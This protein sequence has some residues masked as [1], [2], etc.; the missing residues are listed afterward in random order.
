MPI[1]RGDRQLREQARGAVPKVER[2]SS[3][4]PSG[5]D[6]MVRG[7]GTVGGGRR[8]GA[9]PP[10]SR[11]A[12]ETS[13]MA[14]VVLDWRASDVGCSHEAGVVLCYPVV[15]TL[16]PDLHHAVAE[17]VRRL[18]RD[19]PTATRPEWTTRL[20][21]GRRRYECHAVRVNGLNATYTVM[22]FERITLDRPS[23]ATICARFHLTERESEAVTLLAYGLTNKQ[24]AAR[25][26]V[27]ANTVKAFLHLVM[28]KMGV[29]TR[30][31]ILGCVLGQ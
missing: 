15:P 22:R 30:A 3:V 4:V 28:S 1:S 26:A 16:E 7:Q 5:S 10:T 18:V 17:R 13:G 31:G 11:A 21:S 19:E 25:M 14:L 9:R 12:H 23:F 2:S 29:C 24:I 6:V 8:A 27:S 20:V